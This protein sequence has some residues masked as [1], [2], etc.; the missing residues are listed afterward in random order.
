[1][2]ATIATV[3]ELFT[4]HWPSSAA[5]WMPQGRVPVAGEI[6]RNPEYAEVLVRLVQAGE[7]S[8]A[9]SRE[10]R[11]EA[12]RAAW[13]TGFVAEAIVEFAA[14]PHRHSSGTD[15]AG[16]ISREDFSAFSAGYE[17]AATVEFRGHT[18]AKT[19][20][21]GQGPALL[22]TLAI[23]DGY[24]DAVLDPSTARGIHTVLEAQKLALAD[25]E[26]YYGDADVPLETLLSPEYA[27]ARRELISEQASHEFRPGQVEGRTPFIPPLR[28]QY[29]PPALRG[30]DAPAPG[31]GEPTVSRTG[32][33][34]GDTCHLDVV[35]RWGNI[36][37]AT[38][39]GGWLQ[40][41][42]T[43]PGLGFCLGTRL[44]MTWLEPD[45]PTTLTPGRRPRTTL[46]PTLVLKDGRA[47][48]ALGSPAVTSRTSGSCCTCCARSWA[49]MSPSRR[50][51]HRPATPP[52]CR[53]R[54]GRAPGPRAALWWSHAWARR[55]WPN[56]SGVV[57]WWN[58]PETGRWA[59]SPW[60]SR[61][62]P[63]GSSVP[64]RT[65]AAARATPPDGERVSPR[66]VWSEMQGS[67]APNPLFRTTRGGGGL[68]T[69]VSGWRRRR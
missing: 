12:T 18:I 1:M 66:N 53:A 10:D 47:V 48:A 29:M 30:Q 42:P 68:K 31:V 51:T 54:S 25:R 19:G 45:A 61:I 67:S 33:T 40:S 35:D 23:L 24:D 7:S 2:C 6:V 59:D 15:H 4:E 43:V 8:G 65:P 39:S 64:R 57:T 38:P 9:D 62:R 26:A 52:R 60:S 50:S 21:W 13:R 49:G 37:S 63:P 69:S 56:W 28:T 44:Q 17:P 34:R 20:A 32:E 36:I 55:S 16:V 46:T 58:A 41:S 5:Q 22:Q 3:Q 11:I 27:A 14:T